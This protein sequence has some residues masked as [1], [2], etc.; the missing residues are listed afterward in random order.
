[1]SRFRIYKEKSNFKFEVSYRG[2]D[3][4]RE[5]MINKGTAF[6]PE[7]RHAL[8]LEGLLPSQFNT[9]EQQVRRIYAS[10]SQKA[11]SLDKYV[12]VTALQDRNE[13]LFYRL[14]VDHLEEFMPIIYTPTVGLATRRY[15]QVFKRGRGIWLTP[16]FRGRFA[17]VL[18]TSTPS[19]DIRL[20]VVTDNEAILGIGDQ[21]AGG[22]A[23]SIGK[24]ALY[25]AGA[26][27]H[28][29]Y[30]L[31]V[32][33]DVGTNNQE[34][35]DDDL[36]LGWRNR[37]ITGS[38]Y[39]QLIEEFVKA[40]QQV[41]PNALIQWEDFRKDNALNI[42][43]RY[44]HQ[45][46]SFNDDIQGTGAVALAG[47]LSGCRIS[48]IPFVEQ[49]IV[50]FG[51]GAAGLGIA[52]QLRNEFSNQGFNDRQV[53]QAIAILDSR[54]L[55]VDDRE[56]REEY[57]KELAWPSDL[58]KEFG[59]DDSIQRDL[60][61]VVSIFK[62][63]VLIGSSGQ[64]GAFSEAIVRNMASYTR[65]PVILPLS[66]PTSHSEAHPQDLFKW[67]DGR[68]LV[69]TGSPFED[70]AFQ[71]NKYRISQGNNVFIFPGLG[72]GALLANA[73]IITDSLISA[74]SHALASAV[75]DEELDQLLL[76]PKV[77]RLQ[78]VSR[79]VTLAVMREA[80]AEGICE[81]ISDNEIEQRLEQNVWL[82]DYP[83][84]TAV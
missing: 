9:M 65:R 43:D 36:Y 23:I 67:T 75:N 70:I 58:A 8:G 50:I 49:R 10:I 30:T 2:Y 42:L 45:I 37:R 55:L 44:K 26:G 32:S 40:V 38:E 22:M 77:S 74:A 46:P 7:E 33:L 60:M 83:E 39:D 3:V 82:P 63:T 28:P 52:R 19:E 12:S 73:S 69:A 17:E 48:E 53:K 51:A 31:P 61:N 11:Y 80:V 62:P 1:M 15:S 71:N 14:L 59:F 66:N 47:V 16:E 64:A 21:G 76:F 54:G 41:F 6:L 25:C 20:I 24:L 84:I 78:E 57:K 72:M 79:Q 56:I 34:L 5:P 29:G 81:S 27:I 18:S 35:L 13:H 68:C 4:I